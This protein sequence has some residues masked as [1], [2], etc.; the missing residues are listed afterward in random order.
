[1]TAKKLK[2]E[3]RAAALKG[4]ALTSIQQVAQG[5]YAQAKQGGLPDLVMPQRNLQNVAY[6]PKAGYFEMKG[7]L[8]TRTLDVNSVK[9]F[10]QT[11]RLMALAKQMVAKDDFATKR[12]AYYVSKNWGD[13]KFDEQPESDAVLDDI[14]AMFAVKEVTRETLRFVPE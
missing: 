6:D 4:V 12:E 3:D 7:N 11:L 14:E 5:V 13:A 9:T 2:K 1:M 10:A 8:K